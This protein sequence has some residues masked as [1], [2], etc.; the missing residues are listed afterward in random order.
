[1]KITI[2][3]WMYKWSNFITIESIVNWEVTTLWLT[4]KNELSHNLISKS[5]NRYLTS[6]DYDYMNK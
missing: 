5:L 4:T 6:L 3:V 1:M 2:D